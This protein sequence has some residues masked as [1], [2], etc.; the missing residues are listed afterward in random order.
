MD[1]NT[2][3]GLLLMLGVIIGFYLWRKPTDQ[4]LAQWEEQRIADSIASK[5]SS[6]N[7][8][9]FAESKAEQVLSDSVLIS[10]FFN[11]NIIESD[12]IITQKP[13]TAEEH[14]YTLENS[15]VILKISS[16]GGKPYS[17]QIKDYKAYNLTTLEPTE[18]LILF[19]GDVHFGMDLELNNGMVLNTEK[20]S[21][22][23]AKQDDPS[24]LILT[25]MLNDNQL[26]NFVYN[27]GT[28]DYFMDF[29]VQLIGMKNL[30]K[31]NSI[32]NSRFTWS[33]NLHQLEKAR[34]QEQIYSGL[35]YR[36][37]HNN[38]KADELSVSKTENK[39]IDESLK[40]IAFKNQFFS[41]ILMADAP[42]HHVSL[43]TK[44]MPEHSPYLKSL[45]ASVSVANK[46]HE[47]TNVVKTGLKFYFGPMGYMH[48][49]SYDDGVIKSE[50]NHFEELV[51]LGWFIFGVVNKY[52]IIPVF[53]LLSSS[54]MKMGLVILL[55]TLFVKILISPLTFKSFMSSA[56][57]RV[58]KPQVEEIGKQYPNKDQ[59]AEKQK[60]IMSLYSRAGANPISGCLPVLLQLPFLIA[61][62][63]FFP[64]AIELRQKSFLW[65][66]DLSTYDSI[67]N[68][69][70]HI[71]LLG[72]HLSLFCLLMTITNIV[73]TKFNM[74]MSSGSSEQMPGMKMMMY[75]MPIAF[76]FILNDYPSGLTYYYFISLLITI[77][78]TLIFRYT[79]D[80]KKVL[81]KLE[82]NKNKPKKK[83]GFMSRLEEAQKMQ[84]QMQQQKAQMQK[85]QNKK[86]K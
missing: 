14:L 85:Q 82:A 79:V 81:A 49:K 83:S 22:A 3:I 25:Y 66:H 55:L 17:V 84:Q 4:Q 52:V 56:K 78:L 9:N 59:A 34:S 28:E 7:A 36:G 69:D 43:E 77:I 1:K 51:P 58:L 40:W 31:Q 20:I 73:Y 64:N 35:K 60:A 32:E 75:I 33:Q 8:I 80:E 6:N 48:L 29:D 37:I 24:S 57:M 27:L 21:F 39:Q 45:K 41:T 16:F 74:E 50:Q 38:S 19:D 15:K 44:E 53:Y 54:G 67:W 46:N 30:L 62:F 2:V 5:Q 10:D 26:I 12:S 23:N 18:P 71:P 72:Q 76:L 47:D 61:L 13:I 65:A 86:K 70:M 63:K 42:M 11:S 68:F